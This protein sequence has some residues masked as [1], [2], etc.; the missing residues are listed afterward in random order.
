MPFSMIRQKRNKL[1]LARNH[2]TKETDR[3]NSVQSSLKSYPLRV[4]L[5]IDLKFYVELLNK[6]D[7]QTPQLPPP[8]GEE[9]K[10]II[11]LNF[12]FHL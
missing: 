11:M 7:Q 5:Y 10:S 9:S 6:S 12:Q 3:I 1:T 4:T 2:K 8:N